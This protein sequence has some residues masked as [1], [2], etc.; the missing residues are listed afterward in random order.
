MKILLIQPPHITAGIARSPDSFPF[1]IAYIAKILSKK[2]EVSLLD[3]WGLELNKEQAVERIRKSDFDIVGISALS[4]QYAY[5]KWLSS[6]IKEIKNVKIILGGLLPTHNTDTVLNHTKVDICVIDE[7][8]ITIEEL[9]Q[10]LHHLEKVKGI[11]YK[12]EGEIV[13]T[14]PRPY[15]QNLDE[16]PLPAWDLFPMETY[17]TRTIFK[18]DGRKMNILTG[19]GCPYNCSY[20]SKGFKGVR[21]R[22]ID[23]VIKEIKILKE[24][25]KI[26]TI[27]FS[28]DLVVV[29]KPR[30]LELCKK[31][32]PL[33]L[34]W[35]CQGRVNIVD[36]ELLKEMKKSG[37]KRIGY[38]IESGSQKILNNMN[39]MVT[40]EQ[41]E[42]TIA[43]T[44]KAGLA[45]HPQMMFGMIG[46][47]KETL[48]ETIDFC[49]RCHI[50]PG[51][52]ITTPLPNTKVYEYAKEKGMITD[53][54]KY[55]ENLPGTFKL[56]V[57]LTEFS[58]EEFMDIYNKTMSEIAKNY[59][60]YRNKHP[61][62]FTR[63]YIHK[64]KRAIW[65]IQDFGIGKFCINFYRAVKNNPSILFNKEN[66]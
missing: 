52:F 6:K 55:L 19:R 27:Q 50:A 23:S 11:A 15:I 36:L 62:L 54:E 33:G 29:N 31:L 22:S 34:R 44:F 65:Y 13:R 3:I 49:K 64:I 2:H 16:L 57:N 58:D 25:Y 39:K 40:V 51:M 53:E 7:G 35:S 9:L 14:P 1:G 66:I 45:L 63:E 12:K 47:T 26:K 61:G 43:N 17:I 60:K 8:E 30:T 4:T 5:V 38:G 21:L 28:D 37:C 41:A 56:Y 24:K 10:N 18:E 20:C 46:E 42:K 32:K 48:K 59:A